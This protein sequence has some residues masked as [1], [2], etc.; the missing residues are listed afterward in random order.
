MPFRNPQGYARRFERHQEHGFEHKDVAF[1][2]P[3]ISPSVERD[4][5]TCGHRQEIVHVHPLS[6]PEDVGFMCKQ[7]MQLICKSCLE[8]LIKTGKCIPFEKRIEK[9]EHQERMRI[10]YTGG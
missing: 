7:C 8:E 4:T 6:K 5:F 10:A 3:R 1:G 9:I 2:D